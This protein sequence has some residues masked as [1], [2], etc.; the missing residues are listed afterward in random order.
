MRTS[1]TSGGEWPTDVG[2]FF[3]VLCIDTGIHWPERRRLTTAELQPGTPR[4][5]RFARVDVLPQTR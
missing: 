5:H 3:S 1:S 2:V 4:L